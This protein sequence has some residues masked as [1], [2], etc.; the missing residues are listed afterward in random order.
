MGAFK[1]GESRVNAVGS[2]GE[3]GVMRRRKEFKGACRM[4]SGWGGT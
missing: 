1:L 3:C 2:E 4:L